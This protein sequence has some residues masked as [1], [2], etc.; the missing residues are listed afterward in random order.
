MNCIQGSSTAIVKCYNKHKPTLSLPFRLHKTLAK[1]FAKVSIPS[2]FFDLR[3]EEMEI[4]C[5]TK[6]PEETVRQLLTENKY[7][8]NVCGN[9]TYKKIL[10]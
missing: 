10:M 5:I 7:S 1:S 2:I 3:N 9:L 8:K 6:Y 4:G